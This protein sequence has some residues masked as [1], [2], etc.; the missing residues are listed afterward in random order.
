MVVVVVGGIVVVLVEDVEVMVVELVGGEDEVAGW[1]DTV[2]PATHP[3]TTN[4]TMITA[5]RRMIKR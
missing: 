4:T 5:P 1:D 2:S 3:V